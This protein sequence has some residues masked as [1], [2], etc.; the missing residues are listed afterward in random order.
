MNFLARI[1]GFRG[2]LSTRLSA[3]NDNDP[4]RDPIREIDEPMFTVTLKNSTDVQHFE[5]SFVV[6]K[7]NCCYICKQL[8]HDCDQP[9]EIISEPCKNNLA[10]LSVLCNN[11]KSWEA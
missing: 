1:F 7:P 2:R 3:K 8:L 6:D 4:I 5:Y 11:W 9:E 10:D